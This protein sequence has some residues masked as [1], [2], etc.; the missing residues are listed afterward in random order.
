MQGERVKKFR[1][2]RRDSVVL[3]ERVDW[4]PY[5]S[6]K[7]L[8]LLESLESGGETVKPLFQ[9]K[10]IPFGHLLMFQYKNRNLAIFKYLGRALHAHARASVQLFPIR[11]PDKKDVF[12]R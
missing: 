12:Q 5:L 10:P 1:G 3:V 7:F 4:M 8:I 9:Q 2:V 11:R 6:T